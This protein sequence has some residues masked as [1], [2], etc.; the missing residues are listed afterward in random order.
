MLALTSLA[1]VFTVVDIFSLEVT[2]GPNHCSSVCL[3][4]R[5]PAKPSAWMARTTS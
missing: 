3:R 4:S 1:S 5:S 2:T